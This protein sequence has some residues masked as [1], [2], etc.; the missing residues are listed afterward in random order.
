[1][2]VCLITAPT[3]AEF[4]D[5]AEFASESVVRAAYEPQLGILSLAAMLEVRGDTPRI[6]NLNRTFL[7]YSDS[8]GNYTAF[9]T[10]PN[11]QQR[12][13]QWT[14]PLSMAFPRSAA[15]TL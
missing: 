10:S 4:A 14:T 2:R 3:V 13:L 5:S 7:A 9:Q 15:A 6:V 1:M 12:P 8:V 11:T